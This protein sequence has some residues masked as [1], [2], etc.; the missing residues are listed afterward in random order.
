M[1]RVRREWAS[2]HRLRAPRSFQ[3]GPPR[4]RLPWLR[5]FLLGYLT[6]GALA[7]L[8]VFLAVMEVTAP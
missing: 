5:G 1:R 4:S 7:L 3:P 8:I 2:P 6:V